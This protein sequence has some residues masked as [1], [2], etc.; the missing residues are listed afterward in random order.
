MVRFDS[1][2][3]TFCSLLLVVRSLF[4]HFLLTF[5]RISLTFATR[6][7]LFGTGLTLTRKV[8]DVRPFDVDI[9]IELRFEPARFKLSGPLRKL[10]GIHTE[11]SPL[12]HPNRPLISP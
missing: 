4:A 1:L 5:A 2:S 12:M 10:L 7:S 11:A 3:L 8:L 6:C 9:L